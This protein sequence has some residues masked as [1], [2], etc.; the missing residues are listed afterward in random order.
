MEHLRWDKEDLEMPDTAA[1]EIKD[2]SREAGVT[3]EVWALVTLHPT[4]R[5]SHGHL[6]DTPGTLLGTRKRYKK[7]LSPLL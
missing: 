5:P 1:T 2:G 6:S 4:E 3:G 7:K